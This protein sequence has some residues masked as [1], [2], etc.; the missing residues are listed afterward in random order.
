MLTRVA[1]THDMARAQGARRRRLYDDSRPDA[2]DEPPLGARAAAGAREHFAAVLIKARRGGP[3]LVQERGAGEGALYARRFGLFGGRRESNESP[4]GCAVREVL[5]ETGLELTA[6]ELVPLGRLESENEAGAPTFGHLFLAEDIEEGR[7]S[8]LEIRQ[9]K[10]VLLR[11][12]RLARHYARLTPVAAF[13]LGAYE[14][15]ARARRED[16]P[17]GPLARLGAALFGRDR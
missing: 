3:F 10:G 16:A 4:E 8:G 6:D 17:A 14:D 11:R 1:F 5:E 15:L 12:G 13:A 7:L 2:L 9:G